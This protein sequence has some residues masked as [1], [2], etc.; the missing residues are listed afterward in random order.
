MRI[1]GVRLG[2][3]CTGCTAA[4]L[5]EA[6]L[7]A[8]IPGL[9]G[10]FDVRGTPA[11][12]AALRRSRFRPVTVDAEVSGGMLTVSGVAGRPSRPTGE[13]IPI[14]AKT[15]PAVLKAKS[16]KGRTIVARIVSPQL[17][18]V[19]PMI[20]VDR[21][22]EARGFVHKRIGGFLKRKIVPT[23]AGFVPGGR[24]ALDI[25]TGFFQGGAPRPTIPA[26]QFQF[27]IPR[28]PGRAL[29]LPFAPAGQFPQ[30]PS[31]PTVTT[32][33]ERSIGPEFQAVQGA[34]GLPAMA[35]FAEQRV[36]LDCPPGM[37]LGKDN[38]C[39]PKQVLR[40]NSQF[41][42]W[43]SS[44]RPTI[45]RRDERALA[46]IDSVQKSLKRLGKKAGLKVTG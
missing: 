30:L 43:R 42:K 34:F 37:V 28:L 15:I 4:Q 40:R 26:P 6:P 2:I 20:D 33:A 39:Y 16:P 31:T 7:V 17:L 10:L 27:P 1:A 23:L 44:P 32:P 24:T 35:P 14:L 41:R 46:A 8:Q 18:R 36:V 3:V 29:P 38:L 45:S 21:P 5:Q 11:T 22:A 25:S 19:A 9:D 13:P 12:L